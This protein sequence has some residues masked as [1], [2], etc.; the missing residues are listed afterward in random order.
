M[1]E[2]QILVVKDGVFF[3]RT[4]WDGHEERVREIYN[5][6]KKILPAHIY[7]IRVYKAMRGVSEVV[8]FS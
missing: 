4:E 3:F 1:N 8:T 6:F 7:E 2:Y 5:E